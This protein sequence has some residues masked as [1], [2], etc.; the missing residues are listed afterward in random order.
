MYILDL[1]FGKKKTIK[2][3]V[4]GDLESQRIKGNNNTKTYAWYGSIALSNYKE[5]TFLSK[6]LKSS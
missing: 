1:L 5:K 3:P 2:H 4:L 6:G